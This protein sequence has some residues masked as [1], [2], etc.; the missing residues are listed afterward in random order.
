MWVYR[1]VTNWWRKSKELSHHKTLDQHLKDES[2]VNLP[3]LKLGWDLVTAKAAAYDLHHFHSQT[4][5]WPLVPYEWGHCQ[6]DTLLVFSINLSSICIHRHGWT[7]LHPLYFIQIRHLSCKLLKLKRYF[8]TH[9]CMDLVCS[10]TK[11]KAVKS[12]LF[13]KDIWTGL[14]S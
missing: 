12:Y 7:H 14:F 13:F 3:S 2:V 10:E 6:P 9:T 8:V 11:R 5:Q 1:W 4:I